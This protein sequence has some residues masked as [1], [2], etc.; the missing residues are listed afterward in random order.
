MR[1]VRASAI[2]A[3]CLML[4][5]SVR[6]DDLRTTQS[7]QLMPSHDGI[8]RVGVERPAEVSEAVSIGPGGCMRG[9][10]KLPDSKG[11]T[12]FELPAGATYPLG[13]D[14]AGR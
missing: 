11:A 8:L 7:V 4:F 3:A 5:G 12:A 13:C 10:I 6:A 9:P 1:T 2:F 14:T